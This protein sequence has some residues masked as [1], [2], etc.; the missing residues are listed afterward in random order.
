MGREN[1]KR[2]EGLAFAIARFSERSNVRFEDYAAKCIRGKILDRIKGKTRAD[3]KLAADPSAADEDLL[4][5][6]SQ[7]T[8]AKAARARRLVDEAR[9][10]REVTESYDTTEPI[11]DD[12]RRISLNVYAGAIDT[13]DQIHLTRAR[14]HGDIVEL[15]VHL[16]ETTA[17][18]KLRELGRPKYALRICEQD[19]VRRHYVEIIR[20]RH[21]PRLARMRELAYA[22]AYQHELIQHSQRQEPLQRKH[23]ESEE[24]RAATRQLQREA[25][26]R[27]VARGIQK[28]LK[29][30]K[31]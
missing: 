1:R 30:K 16:A 7:T 10:K 11:S 2:Q 19:Q 27:G 8:G 18:R 24:A 15:T 21:R 12:G 6:Y 20:T 25:I 13:F 28:F 23:R 4:E 26:D 3:R 14:G 22:V 5:L 31:P 17:R 29:E 9:A